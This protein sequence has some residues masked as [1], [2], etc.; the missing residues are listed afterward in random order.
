MADEAGPS[1]PPTEPLA[2]LHL[3]EVTGEK[4]SK[5][6]LK[7]R[8]KQ[9]EKEAKKAEK[10]A[11]APPKPVAAKK[12]NAEADEKELNPNQYFEIR[13]RNI[14]KL[15]QTKNPNPYPHKF[16]ANYDLRKFVTEYGSLKSGE[17]KK[18]VEV[19]LGARIYNKRASGNKLVFYDVRTEGVK[20]QIMCQLQEAKEGGV[21][22]EQQHEHL[23][24]GDIIGIVGYPARTAPKNK[25]ERGE[26][27]E[28]S[29][30]AT[31]IILLTPCLHQLPDEY[32]GFKDQEQRHR[33][34]Y[35]DLIMNDPTRNV[36]LTR[37]KMI[38]FIRKYFDEQDFTEVE[39]PMM[40]P[41]A[42]G[43]TAK[44]FMTH[45]NDLNM[46]M[47]M[48]VAPELYLK[49]LVVGGLN[50]VYE[51]G[52]QFRNEGIDL[53]HNPEFTTCEF[54]MAYADVYDLMDM[55]E[56]LVSGLVKHVTGGTTTKF[57]TQH[58]EE[59]EV[60]WAA[61]WRRVEMI[62]A[63]EEACGEKFPPGDQLH[64]QETNDFLKSILKKMKVDCS[65]PLTNARMLDKLVG[66]FIEETCVNPTFITGHPQMMSPSPNT[67]KEIVNA[68]TELNDPFDQR[69]R[70]EEQARQKDQGDD[71]AQ[72]IDENFC[73]SLEF[74]LPPT[75]GWGMG[76][77][78]LV[79]FLT[80]NYSIKEVLAFPFMKEDKDKRVEKLAAEEVGIQAQSVEGIPHK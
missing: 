8:Q 68:Y 28:L 50:R 24:R 25:L 40:N 16:H 73:Q 62:P 4:V 52:R 6:E 69:L 45:H 33:K 61:P 79:M 67:T 23:R 71:E 48:R 30:F 46:D 27:G 75:G 12:S 22:F 66:E 3:D 54:Y 17:H 15:R 72:M 41:I 26:E 20:V 47:F 5:S 21:P 18:D 58:G 11:A 7:K 35:L 42:G 19:R 31:E 64:T 56:E 32:Y 70:F 63:L 13:S 77:D 38:T 44:P 14:N 59:Y 10:E 53:T 51:I 76:I 80:D 34:R 65:P 57:H 39:T 60:N 2:N 78:R 49:M 36:F 29:I 43:A 74:G 9:R 37:S 55:T 1:A